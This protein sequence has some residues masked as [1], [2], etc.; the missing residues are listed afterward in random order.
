MEHEQEFGNRTTSVPPPPMVGAPPVYTYPDR[1]PPVSN[2]KRVWL[3]V[4]LGIVMSAGVMAFFAHMLVGGFRQSSGLIAI[5]HGQMEQR[6]WDGIYSTTTPQYKAETTVEENRELFSGIDRK[7]G[8]PVS[9]KQQNV[10]VNSNTNGT[11]IRAVF[12]TR[13]S[14][15]ATATETITWKYLDGQYRLESYNIN[16]LALLSR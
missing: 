11:T 9:T 15:D 7:L 3:L 12:E 4:A 13:F 5:L 1:V 10:F 6:D 8:V 16:S 2:K 14:R